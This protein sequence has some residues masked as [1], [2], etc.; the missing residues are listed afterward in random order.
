MHCLRAGTSAQIS[1]TSRFKRD[2]WSQGGS[3]IRSSFCKN[4]NNSKSNFQRTNLKEAHLIFFYDVDQKFTNT[5]STTVQAVCLSKPPLAGLFWWSKV[6]KYIFNHSTGCLRTL[7]QSTKPPLA[8]LLWFRFSKFANGTSVVIS[9]FTF[10][11][12]KTSAAN[13]RF[14]KMFD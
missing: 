4:F 11:K 12:F 3:L 13:L 5:F 7:D 6:Y 8:G 9:A 2:R 10:S 1:T 14:F